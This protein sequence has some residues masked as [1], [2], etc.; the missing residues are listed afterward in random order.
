MAHRLEVGEA[1]VEVEGRAW[2]K[3]IVRHMLT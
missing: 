3:H 1:E 2:G